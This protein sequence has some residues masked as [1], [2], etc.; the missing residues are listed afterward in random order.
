MFICDKPIENQE[1]DF[2]CRTNFANHLSQS[3][4][5]W[6]KKD[7]LVVAIYG[8][9]GS[10]KSS[11]I[12][13]AKKHIKSNFSDKIEI[14]E[15]NPWN[16]SEN[17]NL[18][19][20]FFDE[21]SKVFEIKDSDSDKKIAQLFRSYSALLNLVPEEKMLNKIIIE[22]CMIAFLLG[23][24]LLNLINKSWVTVMFALFGTIFLVIDIF[25]NYSL[26]IAD[27]FELKAEYYS[28]SVLQIKEKLKEKL[29]NQDK[30]L[31]VIIDDIDRLNQLEI[32]QIF[33]LV[34]MN[35]DFPNIIYL[36]SFDRNIIEKNLE[37]QKG[38]SGKD[39]L[40]K[41]VQVAFDVPFAKSE[42]TLHFLLK[43]LDKIL[44][45]LPKS[46]QTYFTQEE[47]YWPNVYHSGFKN[48]FKNIRDV[49]R[50]IS[51]L[52]FNICQMYQGKIMEV[53]P[54]DFIAIEAIRVFTPNF[55]LF[56][57]DKKELFTSTERPYNYNNNINIR[58]NEI[59]KEL[60][61]IHDESTRASILELLK[62]IFPQLDGIF[63]QGHSSYPSSWQ[64]EW[65]N[66]LR[67][68]A[69]NNFDSYFTLYPG[70]DETQLSQFEIE[71]ILDKTNCTENFE[72]IL[73]TYLA[74]N[75]I[76][77]VLEKLQDYTSDQ[78]RIPKSHVKNIITALFNISDNLPNNSIGMM[79]FGID[80]DVM[81]IIY[82]LLKRESDKTENFK[83]LN[84]AISASKGLFGPIEKI[85]LESSRKK[86]DDI[87]VPEDKLKELQEL[88]VEKIKNAGFDTLLQNKNLHIM[89]YHWKETG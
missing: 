35:A 70:G 47:T 7:S 9:W 85:S 18:T 88:C 62:R 12:N 71:D 42:K 76:R 13:L 23:I 60:N 6:D 50:F 68:C 36:L 86:Q 72:K 22:L 32:R 74:K 66:K 43:E 75:K 28:K 11:V 8:E 63:H 24:P 41:I 30:K 40:N 17:N 67:I 57:R 84:E 65:G 87:E 14:I 61:T 56:M 78:K 37:E 45:T 2:L 20:K 4:S 19:E 54:I 58:K 46:A 33:K 52:E 25:K 31:L 5:N 21:I 48:F 81:R 16:F 29:L 34:R 83:I 79:D 3:L 55:Y 39:Y 51:S 53:N 69:T 15:F 38:V 26:K 64:S 59:E 73:N 89:L 49:K 1:E 44:D 82:Q 80:M 27:F 10:G 77:K